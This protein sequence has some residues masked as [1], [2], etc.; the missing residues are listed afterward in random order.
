MDVLSIIGIVL[1]FA[2][3]LGGNM[4]E[5]GTF[6]SLFNSTSGTHRYWRYLG[7]RNSPYLRG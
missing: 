3:I 2:A 6:S 1:A 7:R 5:G 4:V